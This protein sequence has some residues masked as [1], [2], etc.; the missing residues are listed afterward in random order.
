MKERN[1]I[2]RNA[3][4]HHQLITYQDYVNRNASQD[5]SLLNLNA[6]FVLFLYSL[7]PDTEGFDN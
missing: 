3:L 7:K 5:T 6:W 2:K 4:S 1:K